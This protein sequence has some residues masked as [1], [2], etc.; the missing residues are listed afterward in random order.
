MLLYRLG[1]EGFYAVQN[2]SGQ[3]RYLHSDPFEDPIASWS[4][5]RTVDI[6]SIP[7][8]VPILPGKIIGIGRNYVKHAQELNNP[9]PCEPLIFLKATSSVIGPSAPIILPAQSERVDFEG[10]IAVVLKHM[11]CNADRQQASRGI[12]GVTA[13]NDVTARDLQRKDATFAR[14]K[15]FD[16]F[17]PLG[18]AILLSPD[19]DKLRLTTRIHQE[20][21]QEAHVGEMIFD[22][23]ELISYVSRIMTLL[24]GDIILTGTP[25]GVGPLQAGDTVEVEIHGMPPLRNPVEARSPEIS[26][27]DHRPESEP[28]EAS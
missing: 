25:E 24:P 1:P 10:E 12:L 27:P 4:L 21:R 17:C 13:A 8:L 6:G 19:L 7:L 20:V 28:L 9:V 14:A 16:T 18:P 3:V 11:L 2:T 22:I 5:G 15:S 26:S 23:P